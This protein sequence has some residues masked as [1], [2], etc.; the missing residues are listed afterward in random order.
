MTADKK[1]L[2]VTEVAEWLGVSSAWVRDHASGRRTPKLPAVKLG[3]EDGKGLWKFL[4]KDV[5]HFIMEQRTE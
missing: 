5:E 1:L 3:S 4:V 2:S